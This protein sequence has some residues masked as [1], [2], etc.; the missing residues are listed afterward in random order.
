MDI[1]GFK[2]RVKQRILQINSAREL[3]N[4]DDEI[5][6]RCQFCG[7]SKKDPNKRR[8]YIKFNMEEDDMPILY[9][10]FNCEASGILTPSILR[11]FN[12]NDLSINSE[13]LGYNK[14][15][16]K[17]YN[18]ALGIKNNKIKWIIPKPY[19]TELNRLKKKY[20][21][22][23]LGLK[24]TVD[25]LLR[26]KVI[27]DFRQ[28]LVTNHIEVFTMKPYALQNIE[29][30]YIGFLTAKNEFIN[31]RN[32]FQDGKYRYIKYSIYRNLDNTRKFYIIPNSIDVLSADNIHIHI[33]EGI[34]DILGIYYHLY[35]RNDK[36]NIYAAVC[37]AAYTSVVK[38][39]IQLGFAGSNIHLHI[40][41]DKD[42][43]P[44]YY[45]TLRDEISPW[46]GKIHLYYN[47]LSKD[48]G[49]P[50]NQIL[51]KESRI[52]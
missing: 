40:Y 9:H 3:D 1:K 42:K 43:S 32:I 13:L 11:T 38:Y 18:K 7:D 52:K 33:A 37:G 51:L 34:F 8:L 45:R 12:I 16:V 28:F 30:N 14:K 22:N 39:F 6:L 26:L 4:N 15:T 50:K 24:F 21:E 44:S 31:F 5:Q 17:K 48:F 35:D 29:N 19:N 10:C 20:L 36:N 41:S 47:E 25:E 23:R 27:F 46:I 2:F 49:V